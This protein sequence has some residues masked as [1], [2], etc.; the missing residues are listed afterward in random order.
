MSEIDDAGDD[1]QPGG[2][3]ED[4]EARLHGLRDSAHAE[5]RL[6]RYPRAFQIYQEILNSG[7]A[8]VEDRGIAAVIAGQAGEIE[9]GLALMDS[10]LAG[11][12]DDYS[13]HYN[14]GLLLK[15]KGRL[16]EAI[17]RYRTAISLRPDFS[18]AY[19]N[20]AS[21]LVARGEP[22]GAVAYLKEALRR[23]PGY[24]KA[25][26]ALCDLLLQQ[27]ETAEVIEFCW[28]YGGSQQDPERLLG[29]LARALGPGTGGGEVRGT[30][31]D[32]VDTYYRLAQFFYERS[33]FQKAFACYQKVL[34]ENPRHVPASFNAGRILQ[35]YGRLEE[36]VARYR[37]VLSVEEAHLDAL[38]HMAAAQE[39]LY[40]LDAAEA[41]ARKALSIS[42]GHPYAS[43][44]AAKVLMHRE[45]P[46]EA[47]ETLEG[48]EIP[49]QF[50]H[51]F[52]FELGRICDR[53]DETD[54]AFEHFMAGNRSL[55]AA[56]D[57]IGEGGDKDR[58]LDMIS[59]L[60]TWLDEGSG[61]MSGPDKGLSAGV[62]PVFLVGFPRSGTTLL[63]QILDSHTAIRV[64]EEAP[65]LNTVVQSVASM[66]RGYPDALD[67]LADDDIDSL[68]AL[69][70]AEAER[71]VGEFSMEVLVDKM[72]L[73]IVH[74]PL[75]ARIFPEAKILVALRHPCDVCL[76]CFMQSFRQNDAMANFNTLEDSAA[77]YDR[78][79]MLWRRYA[80]ELS[81]PH[82]V[83]KYESL[84]EDH[85]GEARALFDFLEL[86]PD[87]GAAAF[88]EHARTRSMINT[89]SYR[90]VTR[91]IYRS[92][93]Y[94]WVRYRRQLEPVLPRLAR[95]IEYFGYDP[96]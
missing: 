24:A 67:T 73:N 87:S 66:P 16:D 85:E 62:L 40:D 39:A 41:T 53:L 28:Q 81:V 26:W 51:K 8:S 60:E 57:A 18:E 72:P 74:V 52:H 21:A 65:V 25:L 32:P 13:L 29:Y 68:R 37:E 47:L 96:G 91:P 54:R 30:G 64:M 79:M 86:E 34:A 69:Y 9:A 88:W 61:R 48:I 95:H 44:V 42:P 3:G 77:L 2:G 80:G 63:D 17:D 43:L 10:A 31:V 83:V 33:D 15:K 12:P 14:K 56:Y 82:H 93:R 78:V 92:A 46:G 49:D 22:S 19:F 55:K 84:V 71:V 76:S 5:L 36:A 6:G 70:F 75:V 58:F 38:H 45:R 23:N 7:R 27:G 59:A 11:A 94:R 1:R 50:A 35:H 90:Q 20:I 89:P 4:I